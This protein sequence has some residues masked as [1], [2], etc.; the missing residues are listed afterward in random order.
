MTKGAFPEHFNPHA[1]KIWENDFLYHYKLSVQDCARF[2]DVKIVLMGGSPNR[3]RKLAARVAS[4][5]GMRYWCL[6][7]IPCRVITRSLVWSPC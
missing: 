2:A 1:D 4:Q 6:F 7:V 3:M 5:L